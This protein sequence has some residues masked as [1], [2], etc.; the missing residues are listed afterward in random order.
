MKSGFVALLGAPNAGKSTLINK[1]V[2]EKIGIVS[3]KANTTRLLV[4]GILT[5]PDGQV[6]F[7]DT[8]GLNESNKSF[9]RLLV[10]QAQSALADADVVLVVLDAGKGLNARAR[11]IMTMAL[12]TGKPA[13][14]VLNKVDTVQPRSKLLPMMQ[15]IGA[16]YA[17]A[18]VFAVDAL[19]GKG[20][21]DIAA[22]LMKLLPEGPVLYPA[23]MATDAPLP[24]RLSEVTREK[25]MLFL[26]QEIPYGLTVMPEE[27]VEED[28]GKLLVRQNIVVS[29]ER[30]KGMVV[31]SKGAM[32]QKIGTAARHDMETMTGKKIFLDLMVKV[33]E[34]WQ[35]KIN[36]LKDL[37]LTH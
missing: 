33:Q 6:I 15:E 26:Q 31:G 28:D 3:P 29:A 11:D 13:A 21:D 16:Q 20:T 2:G 37:G 27:L 5:Q 23:G 8:P 22:R 36:L 12:Q 35:E 9:D 10:Q 17:F 7:V 1:L 34:D 24:L 18:Q 25:A 4:R 32:I 19:H 14:L 30:H